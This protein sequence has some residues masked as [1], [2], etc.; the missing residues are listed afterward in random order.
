MKTFKAFL[1]EVEQMP[2]MGGSFLKRE[3]ETQPENYPKGETTKH[4]LGGGYTMHHIKDSGTT[5]H[6]YLSHN[7]KTVGYMGHG[8]QFTS[9][10]KNVLGINQLAIHPEHRGKDLALK[11]AHEHIKNGKTLVGDEL[12]TEGT[13]RMWEK[14][15]KKKDVESHM[16]DPKTGKAHNLSITKDRPE[17]TR[18]YDEPIPSKKD[19]EEQLRSRLMHVAYKK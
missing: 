1:L 3:M 18:E 15:S 7:G 19:K 6:S 10:K 17:H 2:G 16:F 9:H 12:H 13:T 14:L 8:G 11:M 5:A 4:D